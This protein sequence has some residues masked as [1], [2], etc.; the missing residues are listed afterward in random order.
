M[1]TQKGPASSAGPFHFKS[2]IS[3]LWEERADQERHQLPTGQRRFRPIE[4]RS[5]RCSV[6]DAQFAHLLNERKVRMGRWYV[7][8]HR[9]ATCEQSELI[10][11]LGDLRAGRCA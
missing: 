2:S 5:E 9:T 7:V 11:N 6:G 1:Q 8:K 10:A 3:G 4:R